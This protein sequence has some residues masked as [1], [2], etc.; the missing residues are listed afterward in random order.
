M[1]LLGGL[2]LL[3]AAC[4][5]STKDEPAAIIEEVITEPTAGPAP[6]GSIQALLEDTPGEDVALVLGTSDFAVGA[7]RV[8]FLVIDE[9]GE[10]IEQPQARVRVAQGGLEAAP[11]VDATAELLPVGAPPE[12][13]DELDAAN[14]Y[15]LPLSV[16]TPGLY[17]LLVEIEGVDVQ[18]VGQ[19]EVA[20]TSAAPAVGTPAIPSDNPTVDDAFPEDITTA[21]PPDVELLQHSV[22][23]SLVDGVP[24]VV[25]FATPKFCQTRVCG[26]VVDIVD[27][28]RQKLD[29]DAVR[30][31]HVEIYE[32]NDPPKGLNE[33]ATEWN[34]PTEPYTFLVDAAGT[35][36]ARFEGL[37]TAGELEQAVRDHLL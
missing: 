35:I 18:A 7:N 24:F 15:V 9:A 16:D 21:D 31:I 10:F 20:E 6:E 1:L 27:A 17:T 30:F 28:V 4:G 25:T 8:A 2:A 23:E 19:I 13:L 3:L 33:W 36:V 11:S 37:V 32:G 26:P 12:S 22:E 5:G 14:V 34:L 29:T